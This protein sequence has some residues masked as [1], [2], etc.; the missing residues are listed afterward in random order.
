MAMRIQ[1]QIVLA[2]VPLFASLSLV[3]SGLTYYLQMKEV[4]WGLQ[5]EASSIAAS[6]ARFLGGEGE[7]SR[8]EDA[9]A[10]G[11]VRDLLKKIAER[12]PARRITVFN[13]SNG[14]VLYDQVGAESVSDNPAPAPD[15][16][17]RLAD[18][19]FVVSPV[20]RNRDGRAYLT[21]WAPVR[22]TQDKTTAVLAVETD[23]TAVDARRRFLLKST[24][25]SLAAASAIGL[26]LSLLISR[27]IT[28]RMTAMTLAVTRAE[29]GR[30]DEQP[31]AGIIE[32][33]N[34]LANTFETMRSVLKEVVARRWR[35]IMEAEQFR[36]D[37]DL[38]CAFRKKF[39]TPTQKNLGGI[40]IA[41]DLL[42]CRPM[43]SV[44]GAWERKDGGGC[45]MTARLEE[46]NIVRQTLSA[47][48]L[49]AYA[50][51]MVRQDDVLTA[52][53]STSDIFPFTQGS[54]VT[55][56]RNGTDVARWAWDPASR[57]WRRESVALRVGETIVLHTLPPH[58]DSRIQAYLKPFGQLPLSDLL[59]EIRGIT[60][61]LE[62]GALMLIRKTVGRQEPT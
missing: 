60:N 47:S 53:Q 41:G 33:L 50:E 54:L 30:H 20:L 19:P 6:T 49:L 4:H 27:I 32:E 29:S 16:P 10:A 57:Q 28:R 25:I 3:T 40:E 48:A 21:A 51:Q 23:A 56:N 8:S 58:L 26:A 39:Q 18:Q 62:G 55:W 61:E 15:S 38:M 13:T 24:L 9:G 37:E 46:P 52:L 5:E 44:Q 59:K 31:V 11:V 45:A 2:L 42:G 34:D 35:S 17:E 22:D 36:T 1:S 43:G 12:S 7:L 14:A